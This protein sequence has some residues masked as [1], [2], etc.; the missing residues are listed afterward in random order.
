MLN[1]KV[2][3]ENYYYE[4]IPIYDKLPTKLPKVPKYEVKIFPK[5]MSHR[6]I[7]KEYNI[8]PYEDFKTAASA[9]A[10]IILTLKNDYKSRI[11][12]FNYENTLYRFYAWRNDAG[13]LRVFVCG[14]NLGLKYVAED[15][16]AFSNG[17]LET[18]PIDTL[19]LSDFDALE[20]RVKTLENKLKML[21]E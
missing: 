20:K 8:K 15:G 13:Q 3:K 21:A 4:E 16:V 10:D 5:T 6:E 1:K 18:S 9:V 17:P 7:L 11:V 14:V 2:L 12:Y 19:K